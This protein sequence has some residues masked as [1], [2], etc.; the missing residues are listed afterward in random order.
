MGP[1]FILENIIYTCC[2]T[3]DRFAPADLSQTVHITISNLKLLFERLLDKILAHPVFLMQMHQRQDIELLPEPSHRRPI[4][5]HFLQLWAAPLYLFYMASLENSVQQH[6]SQK[7]S[8]FNMR[9]CLFKHF[10]FCPSSVNTL[11]TQK[12]TFW[13]GTCNAA[14]TLNVS[15]PVQWVAASLFQRTQHASLLEPLHYL[16]ECNLDLPILISRHSKFQKAH[17]IMSVIS[18]SWFSCGFSLVLGR[19]QIIGF[20]N[21]RV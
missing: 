12:I 6:Y 11:E 17:W 13:L 19:A 2:T 18:I 20:H 1:T 9:A 14:A 8:D 15:V 21:L 7:Q 4:L 16:S 10:S 5:F 3:A